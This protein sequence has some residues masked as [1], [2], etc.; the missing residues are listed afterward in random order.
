MRVPTIVTARLDLIS[1]DAPLIEA[2]LANQTSAAAAIGGF[3]V[4]PWWPD[5]HDRRFLE[6]RLNDLRKDPGLQPWLARAIVLRSDPLKPMA[7]HIGFHGPPSNQAAE[8][9][10]TIF[11]QYRRRGLAQEAI[12]AMM[13]WAH[14]EHGTG[15]F[16]ISVAPDNAPS[17]GLAAKLGFIRTGE[18]IDPEDGLEYVFEIDH[19]IAKAK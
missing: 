3:S 16:I 1:L 18:Q 14:R 6:L 7:G 10:Y 2:M 5:G 13:D 15:R 19:N 11:P 9:G 17:L 8:M 4:P 12:H